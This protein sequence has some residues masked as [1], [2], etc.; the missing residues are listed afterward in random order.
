MLAGA[1]GV[2]S[3]TSARLGGLSGVFISVT[4][5]PAA[6]NMALAIAFGLGDTVLGSLAQLLIN[7]SGMAVAGWLTLALQQASWQKLSAYRARLLKNRGRREQLP[8]EL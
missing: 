6:G 3:L 1:A 4:T 7:L 5:I 8:P 2:L